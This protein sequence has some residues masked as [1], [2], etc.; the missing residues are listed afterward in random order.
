MGGVATGADAAA[1]VQAGADMVGVGSAFGKVHQGNWLAY[2]EALVAD[3]ERVLSGEKDPAT[4][5]LYYSTEPAMQYKQRKIIKREVHGQDT[6]VLTL[7]GRW[8]YEAGQFVFLWIPGIGEKPFSIAEAEPLTFVIKRRGEF[9]EALYNLR[10]G[11]PLYIRGLYGQ[12]IVPEALPKAILVAG[13]TG[14][15]VLP[16][17]AKRLKEQG[18]SMQI[19]VGTSDDSQESILKTSLEKYG[20]LKVVADNGVPGRVLQLVEKA[21]EGSDTACYLV[22]PTPFM[23]IGAKKLVERGVDPKHIHLSL[24]LSTLCGIGMCGECLCGDK[25]TCEWGTF[26]EYDYILS[27]APELLI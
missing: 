21:V 9:T 22:G 24:E 23:S 17:L 2:S 14:V 1:M 18:S 10:V 20:P 11:D 4:A 16:A 26:M 12:A 3:A 5:A 6:I 8:E 15:A 19:F 13:G 27:H 25:L 7:E